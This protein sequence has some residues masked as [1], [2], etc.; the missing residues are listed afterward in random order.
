[1]TDQDTTLIMKI[2]REMQSDVKDLKE[3]KGQKPAQAE[4]DEVMKTREVMAELRCSDQFVYDAFERRDLKGFRLGD[5]LRIYRTSVAA[6]K[7][8]FGNEEALSEPEDTPAQ[9]RPLSQIP[10]SPR[11][12]GR[13]AA[14]I[15]DRHR[16]QKRAS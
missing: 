10:A 5:E 7:R 11:K 2:L 4:R 3:S 12:G 9:A 1:M 16:L 15:W 8:R 14:P 6:F 13:R